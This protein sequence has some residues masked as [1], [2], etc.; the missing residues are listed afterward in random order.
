VLVVVAVR[1]GGIYIIPSDDAV[2]KLQYTRDHQESQKRVNQFRALGGALG[3]V[4]EDASED[5][6]WA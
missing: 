4:F 3:V 6:E 2:G 1:I 5:G